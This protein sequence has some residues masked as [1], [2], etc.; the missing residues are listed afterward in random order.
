MN[1][2]LRL[3][4][5]PPSVDKRKL[6]DEHRFTPR[7]ISFDSWKRDIEVFLN[8]VLCDF[9]SL[10]TPGD[11]LSSWNSMCK[12]ALSPKPQSTRTAD[13]ARTLISFTNGASGQ[14]DRYGGSS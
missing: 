8:D 14:N 2:M 7:S 1:K 3:L 5:L 13:A 12:Q 6:A 11:G 9:E 4:R 10:P